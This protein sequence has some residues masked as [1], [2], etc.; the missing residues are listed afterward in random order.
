MYNSNSNMFVIKR[1]GIKEPVKFDKITERINKQV[2]DGEESILDASLVAQKVVASIYSGI[3]TEE[4]DIETAKICA[5]L[6]TLHPLYSKLAGR[7]LVSNLHK[8]TSDNFVDKLNTVQ[9]ITSELSDSDIGL[10]DKKYLEWVNQNKDELNKMIDYER[11]FN[12]DFFG[13]KTLERAYLLKDPKTKK[14][15][16]RP[17]D[18]WLRV[19]SFLNM[20]NLEKT[21]LTYDLRENYG[22]FTSIVVYP[23]VP[24]GMILLRL[25]MEE[26]ISLFHLMNLK[27]F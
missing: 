24:K 3:N 1:S 2:K 8:K 13:F 19:A 14:I 27:R 6:N 4:L 7:I 21:K 11:D 15:Y 9:K 23:V 5:N 10:L 17:Q 12:M 20:G 16:E 26:K 25:S 22:I 18:M